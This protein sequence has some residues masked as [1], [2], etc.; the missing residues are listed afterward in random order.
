MKNIYLPLHIVTWDGRTKNL[1]KFQRE[2][3]MVHNKKQ[4]P[5]SDRVTLYAFA[6]WLV[7]S[8]RGLTQ[9]R[10]AIWEESED[11]LPMDL[12]I[13]GKTYTI[14]KLLPYWFTSVR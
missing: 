12:T 8:K 11:R 9:F 7:S 10:Q 6:R 14:D 4:T 2:G 1:T 13:S 5:K 3:R